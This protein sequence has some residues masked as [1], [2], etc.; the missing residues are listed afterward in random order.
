MLNVSGLQK[1]FGGCELFDDVAL[2]V[3]SGDRIAITG[4][5]GAGKSTLIKIILGKE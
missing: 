2:N 5:N 3:M 4:P 1:S